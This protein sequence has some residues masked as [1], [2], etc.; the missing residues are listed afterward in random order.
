MKCQVCGAESGKYPICKSCNL[1]RETGEVVK[2]E[3]CGNWHI[4]GAPCKTMETINAEAYL[5]ESKKRLITKS[6][7]EFFEAIKSSIPEKFH[8]FPQINLSSFIDRTDSSRYRNELFRNVDFLI[9]DN[10]YM[11]KIV[12]EINDQSHLDRDRQARDEKVRKI[13]EEA[14]IPII[15]LWTSYGV[16]PDYI[17]NRIEEVLSSLPV[18]RIHHFGLQKEPELK[19]E[20]EITDKAFAEQYSAS[21]IHVSKKGCYI[22]TA[23]YGSYDCPEVWTLRRYRDKHLRQTTLGRLFI[24]IYYAISPTIVRIFSKQDWFNL[25]CRS[26]LDRFVCRLHNRGISDNPYSDS[27]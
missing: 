11:P 2:C 20:Q 18:K 15:K 7:S 1:K 23:V 26:I 6:E 14:G 21:N 8:V 17:Q 24:R 13:C 19:T 3:L 9:T 27:E 16:N 22:A 25:L 4:N 12:I 5:Y 10:E